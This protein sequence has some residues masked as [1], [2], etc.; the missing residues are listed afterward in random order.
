MTQERT[1]IQRHRSVGECLQILRRL[2]ARSLQRRA[3]R[4]SIEA[5]IVTPA[6]HCMPN[7]TVQLFDEAG[8]CFTN[9]QYNGCVLVLATGVEHGLRKLL[10][11]SKN[12]LLHEL[13]QDGVNTGVVTDAEADVL[14]KL[15][16]YRNDATHSNI[17]QLATR[18]ILWRQTAIL[19]NWGVKASSD[20]EKI[21][22]ETQDHKEI[23][24]DLAAERKVGELLVQVREILHDIFDRYSAQVRNLDDCE[25]A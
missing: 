10:K 19:T 24:S 16:G 23:A 2:D 18:T 25:C 22:P 6:G 7:R 15:K 11:S 5:Q 14:Q 17:D 20:W 1:W 13:I 12:R 4:L 21:V 8:A 3:E 9:G